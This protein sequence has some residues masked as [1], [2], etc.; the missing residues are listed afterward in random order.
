MKKYFGYIFISAIVIVTGCSNNDN[1]ITPPPAGETY[2]KIIT[3]ETN[4]K[5]FEVWTTK[6]DTLMTGYNKIGFK[7]FDNNSEKTTGYVKFYAKMFHFNSNEYHA[8]PVEPQYNYNAAFGMFTGYLI[9]LMPGDSTSRWYAYYNYND[10]F[11]ADSIRFD[12]GWDEKTKFKIFT[13]IKAELSYLITVVT[14][15]DPFKGLNEFTCLLHESP[16]FI[17][18]TQVNTAEMYL[19]P[20]LDS[21]NHTSA[22]NQ[23]PVYIG[24]GIYQ[25]KVNFDYTGGWKLYD[26]IYYNNRII[27][28]NGTPYIYFNVK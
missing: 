13:D 22:G 8:T 25:G 27:T 12:V 7:V 6:N 1:V 11:S 21:L 9:M 20:V 4:G 15:E 17:D 14:P 5:R 23:N 28:S 24:G 3:V 2:N 10:E 16:N 19:R 18:F 26:S